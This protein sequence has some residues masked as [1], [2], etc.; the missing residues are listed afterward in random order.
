MIG[1]ISALVWAL[2]GII[3]HC[4]STTCPPLWHFINAL[5]PPPW[6]GAFAACLVGLVGGYI[7]RIGVAECIL[8]ATLAASVLGSQWLAR[9]LFPVP[10]LPQ[11]QQPPLLTGLGYVIAYL[12]AVI[13]EYLLVMA[14][15][16]IAWQA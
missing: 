16:C 3:W 2:A 15:A 6:L 9:L 10:P 4:I 5:C 13:C 7:E 1:K 12:T 14:L 8:I 11:K